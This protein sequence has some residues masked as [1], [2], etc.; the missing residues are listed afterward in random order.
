[1]KQLS[2]T[3]ILAVFCLIASLNDVFAQVEQLQEAGKLTGSFQ[4]D[5]QLYFP[6]S[7]IGAQAVREKVLSNSYLQLTYQ[8][9]GFTAGLRYEAYLD[10]LLGFDRRYTGQGIANRFITYKGDQLEVTAGNFYGQFGNGIV[11]RAYQEWTL[12][13]DNSMDGIRAKFRPFK[14]VTLTGMIGKQR[15]FFDHSAGIVRGGDLNVEMNELIAAWREKDTRLTLGASIVSRYEADT[16]PVYIL[17]ENVAAYSGRFGLRR[18]DFT[19]D[20]EAAWKI[21]DPMSKN[22]YVYNTGSAYY[23][24]GTYARKGIGFSVSAKRIDNFDFRSEREVNFT[25]STLSFLPAISR[26]HTYRLI[27][28]YPYATQFNGEA[29]F[30]GSVFYKIPR[31]SKIGGKYGT[32]IT[33]NF[34]RIV[35]LDTSFVVPGFIYESNFAGGR[36]KTYFDDFS[37]EINRK[38]TSKFTSILS[39]VYLQYNKDIIEFGTPTAGYGTVDVHFAVLE[40]QYRLKTRQAIRTEIQHMY[41]KQDKGS[42][43]MALVEYSVAPN[44]Y[45]TLFDEYNYGNSNPDL[46]VHYY[47]GQVAF[48]HNTYRI[49]MGYGRQRAGLL[50]VGGICRVVPASNGF[51]LSINTTF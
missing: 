5:V 18:G 36:E 3:A 17:P 12:G 14:G 27:T 39:Y 23:L 21:N 1:M 15:R 7:I 24:N 43:A 2:F 49:S 13:I 30:A 42:W 38:W 28:L 37:L 4:T 26:Q 6:D 25:E 32:L 29:G 50:C 34:S 31:N 46:R 9:G 51:T 48:A 33:L 20:G 35:G 47:N 8:Q 40:L 44:W 19:L 22:K 45:F 10:P 11:F 16:D 41:T